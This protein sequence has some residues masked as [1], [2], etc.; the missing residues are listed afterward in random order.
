MRELLV[1]SRR[2]QGQEGQEHRYTYSILIDEMD[3]GSF[4]CES[5]GVKIAES[6]TGAL[7]VVP[8]VTVSIPRID[9]LMERLVRNVV[10]PAALKDVIEDWL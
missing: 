10:T 1:C 8:N 3:V 5:Y 9:E 6:P 2:A 7:A 4:R